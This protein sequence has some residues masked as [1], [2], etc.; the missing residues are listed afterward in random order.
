MIDIK[1]LKADN[2]EIAYILRTCNADMTSYGGFVWP[3]YGPVQAP[4]WTPR[5]AQCGN[6]LHGLLWGQGDRSLLS[7]N[8][9]AKWLVAAIPARETVN[10]SGKHVFPR[11]FVVYCGD[12]AEANL[13]IAQLFIEST[14]FQSR[15]TSTVRDGVIHKSVLGDSGQASVRGKYG[16]A[17][18]RGK[19]GVALV[20]GNNGKAKA[21][22]G[23]I[24][25]T[26]VD[27]SVKHTRIV[28]GYV[29]ENGIKPD[30]WYRLN[31]AH[32]LEE[33]K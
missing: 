10:A 1:T 22:D 28:V 2:P 31:G 16:Q 14:E 18:V 33:A 17:S 13:L 6:G 20:N 5:L 24:V 30:T 26:W 4:N 27:R 7:S 12:C 9:D 3:E 8:A 11:A 25:L 32:E 19:Y 23:T 15:L 21:V 29:G